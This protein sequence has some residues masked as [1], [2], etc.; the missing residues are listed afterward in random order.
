[1]IEKPGCIDTEVGAEVS[2]MLGEPLPIE[3]EAHIRSCPGCQVEQAAFAEW[4]AAY[5]T[6]GRALAARI[7]WDARHA[8]SRPSEPIV[9][10]DR[11][12]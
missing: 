5:E 2:A 1:M 9:S 3:L 7:Y 4:Q 10:D 11:L 12:P 8:L 6:P